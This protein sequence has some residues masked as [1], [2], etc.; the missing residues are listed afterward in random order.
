MSRFF[1]QILSAIYLKICHG[2]QA[3][4]LLA[5]PYMQISPQTQQFDTILDFLE[6]EGVVVFVHPPN[7]SCSLQD[8]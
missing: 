5:I 1:T 2:E 6:A 8:V 4:M 3:K 7:Q